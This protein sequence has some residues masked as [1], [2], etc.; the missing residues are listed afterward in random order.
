L[1]TEPDTRSA[2]SIRG[3]LEWANTL[4]GIAS[5][6]VVIQHLG[7]AFFLGL[8]APMLDYAKEQRVPSWPPAQSLAVSPVAPGSVVVSLFFLLSGLVIAMSLN[9]YS[10]AGFA[11]ARAFRILPTFSASFLVMAFAV[12]GANRLSGHEYTIDGRHTMLAMV[13]GL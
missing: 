10:R 1:D 9:R 12:A 5:V 4:R 8:F 6:L 7:G 11:V 2:E 13:P 3:R